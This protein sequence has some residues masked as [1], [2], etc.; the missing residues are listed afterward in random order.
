MIGKFFF[1]KFNILCFL[2]SKRNKNN[3]SPFINAVIVSHDTN[4]LQIVD[5]MLSFKD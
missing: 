1:Y 3:A 2:N 4:K 5:Y